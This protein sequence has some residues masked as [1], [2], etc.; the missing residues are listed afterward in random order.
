MTETCPFDN[1]EMQKALL[2]VKVDK[3]TYES[4]GYRCPR[5]G[6]SYFTPEQSREAHQK[7]LQQKTHKKTAVIK[8]H[9]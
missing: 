2:K 9:Q 8:T 1:S 4:E 6:F 7:Y 3:I 5:C